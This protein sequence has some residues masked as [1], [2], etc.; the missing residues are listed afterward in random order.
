MGDWVSNSGKKGWLTAILEL[1]A[2]VG[3]LYSGFLAEM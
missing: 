1:G 2:W 3:C